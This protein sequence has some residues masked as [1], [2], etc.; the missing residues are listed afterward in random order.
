MYSLFV[1]DMFYAFAL[2]AD[3]TLSAGQN[4]SNG[5]YM[6]GIAKQLVFQG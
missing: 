5:T 6:Y 3:A 2:A 4:V 1:F